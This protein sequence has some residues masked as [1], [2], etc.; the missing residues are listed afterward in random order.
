MTMQTDV[1]SAACAAGATTVATNFRSRLKALTLSY[2][3][4]G[5]VSVTDSASGVT[6]FSF[7]APTATGAIH[8][9]IPGQGILA[10][11]GLSVTCSATTTAVAYYG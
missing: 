3:A 6:L 9:L 10:E 7:T 4:S 5:T 11:G 2:A 1:K 8:I